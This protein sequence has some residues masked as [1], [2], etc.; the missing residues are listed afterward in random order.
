MSAKVLRQARSLPALAAAYRKLTQPSPPAR[1]SALLRCLAGLEYPPVLSVPVR[2][3]QTAV[4]KIQASVAPKNLVYRIN[5]VFY[6]IFQLWLNSEL[7]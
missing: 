7:V 1:S 4:E 6:N 3:L 2:F 5:L